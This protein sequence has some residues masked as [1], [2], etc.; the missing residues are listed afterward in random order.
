LS[1]TPEEAVA[2]ALEPLL[3]DRAAPLPKIGVAV[4]GGGDSMALLHMAHNWAQAQ[5]LTVC[6][7]T[8]NHGLRAA[9]AAEAAMVAR[10]C[11]GLGL[12]HTTLLWQGWNQ[13]GNVQAEARDAR[14]ALLAA[15]AADLGL[16]AVLLGHT[17]DDQAETFLMRLAR[18]SGVDGLSGMSPWEGGGLFLRPLLPVSRAALRDWLTT[19]GIAWVDDPSNDDTRFDRVKA[20]QMLAMLAPLGLTVDRL[21]DTAAHMHRA[22]GT[23]RRAA[24]DWAARFVRAEGGDLIFAHEALHLG[25][26]DTEA[27]VF[28][29]AVQWIGGASYRPRYDALL[30]A[31]AALQQGK[32]RT[33]GGVRM[34]PEGKTGARL[35]RE[36]S[37]VQGPVPVMAAQGAVPQWDGR[38]HV[39]QTVPNPTPGPW[40]IAALGEAG[41]ALCPSWRET[42]LPR[43]S[44]LATPAVWSDGAL[45]AAPLAGLANGWQAN[46]SQTFERFVLSH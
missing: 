31:A 32:A 29:A 15:W 24:A 18:G 43:T 25:H 22:R 42:G 14:R 27:R 19:R 40:H 7:A 20:R 8:V 12:S 38:W 17:A 36:A 10:V 46:L 30:D 4:S 3:A 41:L 6:V 21:N 37:A 45:I 33:L 2:R 35:T 39:V 23:L 11:A 34:L 16:S 5:G 9:A 44:L 28:A 13:R 26:T 1:V